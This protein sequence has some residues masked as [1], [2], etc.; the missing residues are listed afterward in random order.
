MVDD[1]HATYEELA[2]KGF[3]FDF[4]PR[5]MPGAVQ[6]VFRNSDGIA[7]MPVALAARGERERLATDSSSQTAPWRVCPGREL[8][9]LAYE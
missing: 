3:P 6:A 1:V 2:A 7:H 4:P 9:R 5:E 8:E